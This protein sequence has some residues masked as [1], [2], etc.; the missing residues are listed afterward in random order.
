[1]SIC[2]NFAIFIGYFYLFLRGL[3]V[4]EILVLLFMDEIV[5]AGKN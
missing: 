2:G 4:E 5:E 3:V 1:M